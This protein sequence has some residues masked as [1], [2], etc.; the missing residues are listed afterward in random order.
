M[1]ELRQGMNLNLE[2]RPRTGLSKRY[3]LVL[4]LLVLSA[5]AFL[6]RTNISIAGVQIAKEFRIDNAHLGWVFS[7][8]LIGY[9]AFQVPGGV[10]ARRLGPRKV[11]ALSVVWWG[12]F[13]GLTALVP[14]TMQGGLLALVL[15]RFALG[16]GEATMYPAGNQFVERW[17]PIEE[18][19]KAS[20]IIFGGVGLG[21]GLTPPL[22]TAIIVHYGWRASFWFSAVVG[23][24][25]G[26]I[27]YV[28]ARDTPEEHPLVSVRELEGIVRGRGDTD[29]PR[30]EIK[31]K[32]NVPWA[33]I[34]GSKE[35]LAVTGSYFAFGYVAWIFFSWFYI[36]LAQV[37]GLNLKT[38]AVYSMFPF[39]AM[40][41][42]SLCGGVAS[43][44]LTANYSPRIGRCWLP[45]LAQACTAVLLV[46]GSRVA[47]AQAASLV[48]ACGAGALYVSQSCFWSV[49]ADFAGQHVGVAS[50]LMNMGAQVGGAVTASLT[51]LIA[52]RFGWNASFLTAA[53]LALLGAMA[54]L[55][56]D[57]TKKLTALDELPS[58]VPSGAPA[59]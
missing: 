59:R 52:S 20:G 37:R 51:P 22:V 50:G 42:G 28:G 54:W 7:A 41:V 10:L 17:F 21:S 57:P 44:W 30:T 35:I 23:V 1:G 47:H 12:V 31:S 38:S 16:A 4:W 26:I 14:P 45:S 6:D 5:V 13:T 46:V 55:T 53:V 2:G 24:V 40:T 33:R 27:W 36:Y 8:F 18:R 34:F 19:G 11:L 3:L 43:D 15:V 56:V 32:P 48:L 49:T 9:A 58:G 25:A 39:I 29:E